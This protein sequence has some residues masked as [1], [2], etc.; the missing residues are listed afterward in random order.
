MQ[1]ESKAE[2]D[3]F[4]GNAKPHV[5]GKAQSTAVTHELVSYTSEEKYPDPQADRRSAGMTS[6]NTQGVGP[7]TLTVFVAKSVKKE[8]SEEFM[9]TTSS[10]SL[11]QT[12]SQLQE[13][14][15]EVF[16]KFGKCRIEVKRDGRKHPFA[17]VTYD[18]S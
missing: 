5:G 18:V 14:M 6:E 3:V 2:D 16:G 17:F 9:L 8:P 15:Y 11:N 13:S 7:P 1:L 4:V 12:D 10:L